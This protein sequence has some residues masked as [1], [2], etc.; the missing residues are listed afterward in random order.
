MILVCLTILYLVPLYISHKGHQRIL[1]V[2]KLYILS[3]L[4][5]LVTT[6]QA[7]L[8]LMLAS[9]VQV[10]HCHSVPYTLAL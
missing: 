6:V 2:L 3:F 5:L 7:V 8:S 4:P 9:V 1:F 10:E